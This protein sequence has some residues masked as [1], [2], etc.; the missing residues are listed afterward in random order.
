M[1]SFAVLILSCDKYSDLWDGFFTL[2]FRNF[3][4]ECKIYLANNYK[5]FIHKEKYIEVLNC[6]ED[7]NWSNHFLKALVN[8]KEDFVFVILEDLFIIETVN[9]KEID[10][11][12]NFT[13]KYNIQYIKYFAFPMGDYNFKHGFKK[14]SPGMPYSVS[15]C[16]IWN[17]DYLMSLLLDGET[18]WDFEI[19]GSYRSKFSN[20]RFYCPSKPLF[21]YLNMVEKGRWVLKNVDEA[22]KHGVKIDLS[23]RPVRGRLWYAAVNYYF[24]LVVR[25]VPFEWRL[26]C[27]DFIKKILVSY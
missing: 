27:T 2:F 21:S 11:L 26:K 10:N 1:P 19:N 4:Y 24:N 15:V 14:Y 6:G 9:N 12:L 8:I 22:K 18:A 5:D 16:G 23:R 25:L 7:K 20:E 13:F 3:N 17:K